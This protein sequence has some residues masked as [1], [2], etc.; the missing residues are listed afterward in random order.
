MKC[1]ISCSYEKDGEEKQ[2]VP[3]YGESENLNVAIEEL[4][5]L[6]LNN[7]YIRIQMYPDEEE[8]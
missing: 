8:T 7:L 1:K 6:G 5:K 2:T 3:Y 4:M